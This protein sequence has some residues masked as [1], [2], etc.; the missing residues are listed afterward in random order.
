MIAFQ[1]DRCVI[2]FNHLYSI[3]EQGTVYYDVLSYDKYVTNIYHHLN[4]GVSN[5]SVFWM[6]LLVAQE[7]NINFYNDLYTFSFSLIILKSLHENEMSELGG[8][9]TAMQNASK[10]AQ[11][12]ILKIRLLFN[13]SRQAYITN[14]L[15]EIVSCLNSLE[16]ES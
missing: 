10:N 13:K 5:E 9:I 12:L 14:E 2:F 15:I 8:R 16:F 11:E 3:F 6:S 7:D 1:F 4:S